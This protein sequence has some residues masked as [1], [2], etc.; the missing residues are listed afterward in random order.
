VSGVTRYGWRAFAL[1]ALIVV[2]D[3]LSKFWIVDSFGLEARGPVI[4]PGPVNLTWVCNRGVSFG[5]LTADSDVTRWGLTAFAVIVAVILAV[6]VRKADKMLFAASVGLI[7]GGAIGNA[8]D[9]ARYGCVADFIDFSE[10]MFPWV[11]N[12]A[13]AA[14]N[15]GIALMIL[16][17]LRRERAP[18]PR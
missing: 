14:I 4:L 12:V 2:L 3:Q 10:L 15:V 13:D 17:A 6:W 11:F 8:I 5:L 18:Q 16:D 1:A 7:I 9:R